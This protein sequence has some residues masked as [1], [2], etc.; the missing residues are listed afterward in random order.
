MNYI[1]KKTNL[2]I[3]LLLIL[4]L[5]L[6]L[7]IKTIFSPYFEVNSILYFYNLLYLLLPLEIIIY[8]YNLIKKNVKITKYDIFIYLLLIIGIIVTINA[9]DVQ[10]S[11]WG[12]YTRDEGLLSLISYYILFL[13]CKSMD[14]KEI[15]IIIN[16]LF[17]VG[18]LQFVYCLLQVFVRGDYVAGFSLHG[19]V[20]H[21]AAGFIGN[22]NFLAS[23]CIILLGLAIGF[24]LLYGGKKYLFLSLIFYIN[25]ILAQSTGQFFALIILFI[26]III[27]LWKKK[28]ID[29][30]KIGILFVSF[31]VLFLLTANIVELYVTKVF[32]DKIESSYTIKGDLI[33]TLN[34]FSGNNG[35]PGEEEVTL[36]NYGSGRF[37]IWKNTLKIVPNYFWLGAGYD[38]FG[39]VYKEHQGSMYYDKAH[40]EYLQ[41][42]VTGG[43]F[44]LVVYLTLLFNLFI[45]GIKSNNKLVWILLFAFIGYALQA[46]LNISVINVAFIFYM[47]MG[48]L[49]GLVTNEKSEKKV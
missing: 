34:L 37:T 32:D 8:V 41:L 40:N 14:K 10:T 9:V 45:D 19:T 5:P 6:D 28:V 3:I 27:F 49:A 44:H 11:I 43:I 30:K 21:M 46:F 17:I 2:I 13:N 18:I 36:E 25:L 4:Y 23:Y 38:N 48:M 12:A 29:F 31:I 16:T 24:Y 39:Y 15:K 26:F 33:N 47:I 35:D 42:L 22:P 1:V 20:N 7:M